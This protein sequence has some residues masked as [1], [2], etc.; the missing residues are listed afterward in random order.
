MNWEPIETAPKLNGPL[1]MWEPSFKCVVI[2]YWDSRNMRWE[3]YEG[4]TVKDPTHWM[5]LPEEPAD[6]P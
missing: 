2:A 3:C 6:V 4:D 5:P 1:L